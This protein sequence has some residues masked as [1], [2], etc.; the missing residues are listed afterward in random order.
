MNIIGERVLLVQ[1]VFV[2]TS[3]EPFLI[4]SDKSLSDLSGTYQQILSN[5]VE[6]YTTDAL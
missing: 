2:C 6:V 4:Q 5:N 3:L 1:M